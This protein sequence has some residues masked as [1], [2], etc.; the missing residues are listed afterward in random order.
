MTRRKTNGGDA[1]V[2]AST[3]SQQDEADIVKEIGAEPANDGSG[4]LAGRR[5][6]ASRVGAVDAESQFARIGASK[7][8]SARC[9][10]ARRVCSSTSTTSS[11]STTRHE[12]VA[13][14]HDRHPRQAE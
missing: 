8:W 9:E 1:P 4:E 3:P 6:E 5:G 11:K 7:R 12:D 14:E 2:G 10:R 13:P